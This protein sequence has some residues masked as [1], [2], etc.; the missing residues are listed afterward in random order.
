MKKGFILLCTLL[1]C[2]S[3]SAQM[4]R[5]IMP[6]AY[7]DIHIAD[8]APLIISDSLNV[9]SLWD[10]Y[11][12]HLAVTE[13]EIHPFREGFAVTTERGT[14]NITGFFDSQGHFVALSDCQVARSYPYFSEGYLLVKS[15][16]VYKFINQDGKEWSVNNG[17]DLYPMNEGFALC[18][19]YES[20]EKRK[21]LHWEYLTPDIPVVFAYAGKVFD[22]N[23]VEFLSSVNDEG[24]GIAV[25]R[26]K[27]YRFDGKT[28]ML[29]PLFARQDETNLKKQLF[30]EGEPYV[31][32][33][34]LADSTVLIAKSGKTDRVTF[35]FD[36]LRKLMNICFVDRKESYRS[37]E[38]PPVEYPSDLMPVISD[39]GVYG[40]QC[41]D[42]IVLP[43][44]FED[45]AF[46][47]NDFAVVKNRGKW[48]MLVFDEDLKYRVSMNKGNDIAFRHQYFETNVRIDLP[49]VIAADKCRFDMDPFYGCTIDKTSGEF[50]NTE[51]GNY[52]QYNCVLTI[53]ESLPDVI[54]EITYPVQIT[55]DG[56]V[57][58]EV[59]LITKGW[60]YKYINVDL[61]EPETQLEQGDVTFTINITAEKMLGENDYPFEVEIKTDSLRTELEKISETR[62][63]CKMYSLAEGINN[64]NVNVLE[65]GCPPAVFPFVVNYVPNKVVMDENN[66]KIVEEIKEEVRIQKKSK[67]S[68]PKQVA[69]KQEEGPLLPV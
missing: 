12:R 8:G 18:H 24:V 14:D 67:A 11:G 13:D 30:V 43:Y 47:V 40:I 23:D 4:S 42:R 58:P 2:I 34:T 63:R 68:A 16:G 44:Q 51:S 37:Y 17:A 20:I 1:S 46:C 57:H 48:G 3:A 25:I 50:K 32:V 26:H 5:W 6:P 69:P 56:L 41:K 55:Y 35:S 36:N 45:V 66:T 61:Y 62:Y 15:R 38:E 22:R 21:N 60:H 49:P 29:E 65:K 52:V 54:T 31:Y 10:L 19:T 9:S 27:V 39:D 33:K 7:D 53:P 64:V 28:R 59:Q